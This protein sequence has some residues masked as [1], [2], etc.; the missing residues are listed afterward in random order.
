MREIRTSG[1]M[2]GEGRRAPYAAPRPSSTQLLDVIPCFAAAGSRQ[3]GSPV[4]VAERIQ[5]RNRCRERYRWRGL[6]RVLGTQGGCRGHGELV[7]RGGGFRRAGAGGWRKGLRAVRTR[8][9]APGA[10]H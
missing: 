3:D 1:S 10:R 7:A 9:S 8:T 4:V 5:N 2:S 6:T